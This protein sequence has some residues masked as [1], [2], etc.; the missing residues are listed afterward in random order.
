MLVVHPTYIGQDDIP[1]KPFY[2]T[3]CKKRYKQEGVRDV[4]LDEEFMDFV[5]N[6]VISGETASRQRC[7][8]MAAWLK[9][10]TLGELEVAEEDGR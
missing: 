7:E 8:G 2:C 5:Y 10:N 9:V 4:T 6:G 3:K 1:C